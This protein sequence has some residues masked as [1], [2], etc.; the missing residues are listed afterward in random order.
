[1]HIRYSPDKPFTLLNNKNNPT[2]C[3]IH[4]LLPL[5]LVLFYSFLPSLEIVY[6]V[7]TFKYVAV[8]AVRTHLV[9]H[10]LRLIEMTCNKINKK[11]KHETK[12][13]E[14]K[15]C[16]PKNNSFVFSVV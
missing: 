8:L 2:E 13:K 6:Y 3:N 4:I 16:V 12:S 14:L 11:L 10:Y 5:R 9:W 15:R 7:H 1:M